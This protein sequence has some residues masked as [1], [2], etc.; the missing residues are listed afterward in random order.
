MEVFEQD[1]GFSYS[2][3][4]KSDSCNIDEWDLSQYPIGSTHMVTRGKGSEDSRSSSSGFL[5]NNRS[6]RL[7]A[8][9]PS[10]KESE[11]LKDGDENIVT[12]FDAN[13]KKNTT[14][15]TYVVESVNDS[16]ILSRKC[17]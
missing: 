16:K 9:S 11:P 17:T 15:S 14:S 5:N 13:N 3:I 4:L 1:V 7:R 6:Y 12:T 2:S 8:F 10:R